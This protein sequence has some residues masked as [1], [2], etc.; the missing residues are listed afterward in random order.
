MN[1]DLPVSA[2][3]ASERM[4]EAIGTRIYWTGK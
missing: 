1:N 4:I 2:K 3:K